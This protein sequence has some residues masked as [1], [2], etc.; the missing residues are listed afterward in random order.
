MHIAT[1]APITPGVH[2][3]RGSCRCGAVRYE[4]DIDLTAGSHQCNCTWCTKTGWWAAFVKPQAFRLL[5]GGDNLV[6]FA[7]A[8]YFQRDRCETCGVMSFSTGDM[9]ELGGAFVAINLRCL[10]GVDL[11][12]MPVRYLDGLHDTWAVLETRPWSNVFRA[13]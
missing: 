6:P 2:T 9:P 13:A 1:D 7:A 5:S 12:G 3:Q 11:T 8:G 4:V 10:D